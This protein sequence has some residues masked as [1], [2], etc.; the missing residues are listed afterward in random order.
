[1]KVYIYRGSRREGMYIYLDSRERLEQLPAPVIQQLGTTEFAMEIELTKDRKLGQENTA[2]VLENLEKHG[3]HVQMPKDIEEQLQQ[4]AD[5]VTST[6]SV[7][8]DRD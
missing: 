8:N 6:A 2:N 7:K 5:Q 4:A 3:F 1:M